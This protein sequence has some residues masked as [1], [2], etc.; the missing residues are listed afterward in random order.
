MSRPSMNQWPVYFN[1]HTQQWLYLWDWGPGS[2]V[3]WFI[4]NNVT[5]NFR[6][7]ESPDLEFTEDKCPE[8]V[9]VRG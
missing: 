6:G 4:S 7:I 8:Q 1:D 5:S 3:N 9:N 2:G